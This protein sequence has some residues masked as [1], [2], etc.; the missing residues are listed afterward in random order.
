MSLRHALLGLVGEQPASGYDL[1]RTF[2]TSLAHVWP[3]TQS[4]VYSEL[5]KLTDLG[6]LQVGAEGPR[7]RKEYALTASGQAELLRWLADVPAPK[8]HRNELLLRVFFLNRLTPHQA[9]AFLQARMQHAEAY[10]QSLRQVE[11]DIKDDTDALAVYGRLALEYGLRLSALERD[12]AQWSL[13]QLARIAA[14]Q[15]AT[16]PPVTP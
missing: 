2:N 6:L 11:L 15:A 8:P 4:Q 1:L 12:W 14:T 16:E 3:A 10:H 5:N 7:G 9:R 13:E